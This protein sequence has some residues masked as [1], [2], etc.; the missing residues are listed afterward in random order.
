MNHR[1]MDLNLNGNYLKLF[2]TLGGAK[3]EN[4]WVTL[5]WLLYCVRTNRSFTEKPDC[6][7][8]IPKV[9]TQ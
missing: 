6:V 8:T 4:L 7:A 9:A 5:G 2:R 3:Q 1:D